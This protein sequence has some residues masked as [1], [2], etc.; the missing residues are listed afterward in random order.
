[1]HKKERIQCFC[2]KLLLWSIL[3]LYVEICVTSYQCINI[4][5]LCEGTIGLLLIK[6]NHHAKYFMNHKNID[7]FVIYTICLKHTLIW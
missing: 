3:R 1:M 2:L 5:V 4:H 6:E 7:L